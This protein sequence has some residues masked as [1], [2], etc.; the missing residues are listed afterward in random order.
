MILLK[1]NTAIRITHIDFIF[2]KNNNNLQ[3]I[4]LLPNILTNM[5]RL[6]RNKTFFISR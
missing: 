4:F 1:I 3:N 2:C 5:L 6:R